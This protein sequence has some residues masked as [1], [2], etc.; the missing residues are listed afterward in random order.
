MMKAVAVELVDVGGTP[1][2]SEASTC[3][4]CV[5]YTV[6]GGETS[7]DVGVGIL[8]SVAKS[9]PVTTR[10]IGDT[11]VVAQAS[12][13]GKCIKARLLHQISTEVECRK[14]GDEWRSRRAGLIGILLE[15]MGESDLRLPSTSAPLQAP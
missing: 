7:R 8:I 3:R 14:V 11:M 5:G 10:R 6:V 9:T 1:G 12:F 2:K 15:E 13:E 4:E